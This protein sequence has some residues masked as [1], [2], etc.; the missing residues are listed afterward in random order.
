[1]LGNILEEYIG[2]SRAFV[3]GWSK[4]SRQA[5]VK[6]SELQGR[7]LVTLEAECCAMTKDYVVPLQW[8]QLSLM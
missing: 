4:V 5:L 7:D 8:T 3:M 6:K 2:D 1:M